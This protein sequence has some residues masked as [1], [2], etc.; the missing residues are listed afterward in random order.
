M[1]L[2]AKPEYAPGLR[3]KGL[4]LQ[5]QLDYVGALTALEN[6]YKFGSKDK[7]I[8]VKSNSYFIAFNLYLNFKSLPNVD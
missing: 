3:L 7:D 5:D 4:I 8:I 2:Q 6:A 1:F